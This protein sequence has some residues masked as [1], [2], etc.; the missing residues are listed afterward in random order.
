M[1]VKRK[2]VE[3]DRRQEAGSWKIETGSGKASTDN[4]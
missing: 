2:K 3:E 4:C 1:K